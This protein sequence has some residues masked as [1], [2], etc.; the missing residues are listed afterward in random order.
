MDFK[1]VTPKEEVDAIRDSLKH[2]KDIV[3]KLTEQRDTKKDNYNKYV[4]DCRRDKESMDIAIKS[5]K[6]QI[7]NV[8]VDTHEDISRALDEGDRNEKS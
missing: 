7:T 8:E 2:S 6:D 5:M 4:E 3:K 1:L